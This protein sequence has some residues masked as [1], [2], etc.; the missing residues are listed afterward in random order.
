MSQILDLLRGRANGRND[1]IEVSPDEYQELLDFCEVHIWKG[2]TK[3]RPPVQSTKE[4]R[5]SF[6]FFKLSKNRVE[7]DH[8]APF[9][10]KQIEK[11]EAARDRE[12]AKIVENIASVFGK[13]LRIV[14]PLDLTK[15]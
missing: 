1:F 3:P 9:H 7:Y 10:L 6:L 8:S 5:V 13:S 14:E 11:W 15:Q 2:P 12:L 4:T